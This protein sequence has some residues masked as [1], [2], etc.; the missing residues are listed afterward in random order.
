MAG[1]ILA[2]EGIGLLPRLFL[3]FWPK[4]GLLCCCA[5]F[6]QF[7]LVT[8][9]TLRSNLNNSKEEEKSITKQIYISPQKKSQNVKIPNKIQKSENF[10]LK[11]YK[12]NH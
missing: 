5:H 2:P 11:K 3:P 6:W 7:L 1:Q 12:L 4:K 8:L 9:V 10:N